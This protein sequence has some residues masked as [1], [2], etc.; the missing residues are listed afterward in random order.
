[1]IGALVQSIWLLP[2]LGI[3]LAFLVAA[4]LVLPFL[5]VELMKK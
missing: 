3:G 2:I 4:V 1:M 5:I